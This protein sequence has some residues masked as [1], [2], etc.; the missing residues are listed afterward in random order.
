MEATV[1]VN[2][3]G[4]ALLPYTPKQLIGETIA[5]SFDY[6]YE[7]KVLLSLGRTLLRLRQLQ[8]RLELPV[9]RNFLSYSGKTRILLEALPV[10]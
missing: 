4:T 9:A 3:D 2:N 10:Q 5:G 1:A 8:S 6:N 7:L